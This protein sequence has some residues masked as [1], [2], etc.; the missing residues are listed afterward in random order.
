[1]ILNLTN[2]S[3]FINSFLFPLSRIGTNC[4]L[5]LSNKGI[6]TLLSAADNT[7]ILYGIYEAKLGDAVDTK[8]NIPDLHRLIKV[9]QCVDEDNIQLQVERNK[10]QYTSP[11]LRFT[12]HLLHDGILS[13]PPVNIKKIK[14]LSYDTTFTIPYGSFVNLLKSSTFTLSINKMYFYTK[15][16]NVYADIDDKESHNVDSICIK[17]CESFQGTPL[18]KPLP[19]S[20]ETIRTLAGLK[21]DELIVKVNSKL[22]VMTFSVNTGNVKITYIVSGLIK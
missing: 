10:I 16:G 12:Y 18:D 17:M 7:V 22:N 20:F 1:M 19:V 13:I 4:I 2:K 6:T 3:D 14:Q 8:L 21:C 9:L 5:K 11:N 15:D